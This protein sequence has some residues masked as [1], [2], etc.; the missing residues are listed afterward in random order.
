M[1]PLTEM[2]WILYLFLAGTLAWAGQEGLAD[3]AFDTVPFAEWQ[4]D[5]SAGEARIGWTLQVVPA[6]LTVHQRL[7]TVVLIDMEGSEFKKRSKP[8]QLVVFLEFRDRDGRAYRTHRAVTIE[9]ERKTPY[10][11]GIQ[12][13]QY[14]FVKDGDFEIAAAIYDSESKEH[15]L[16]RAKLRVPKLARDPLPDAWMD[17]PNLEFAD[18]PNPPDRWYLPHVKGRLHLPVPTQRPI[19]IEVLVNESPTEIATRRRER[20]SSRNMGN[21]IPALKV[22]TQLNLS[23]GSMNVTMLDLERRKVS[24]AQEDVGRLNWPRLRSALADNDPSRIDVHELENHEQNAQFFVAE[25]KKRLDA[26][27]SNGDVPLG[28]SAD[29]ARVLIVLSAPM[30]FPKGQDLRPIDAIPGSHVFYI[31][32]GPPLG[33]P[34]PGVQ[35]GETQGHRGPQPRGL[36]SSGAT[37]GP[38]PGGAAIAQDSLEATLKPLAPRR[39][40]VTNPAQFRNALA[41]IMSEISRIK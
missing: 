32:Y 36:D 7:A 31:R 9:E 39:F 30:A 24:F 5:G 20:I 37:P 33:P 35:M 14:A 12:F 11:S 1:I 2:R 18:A 41:A 28:L 13:E 10:F 4:K 16:K 34:L 15:S 29:P 38:A 23:D 3:R 40:D 25:V 22:I 8:G 21:L 27:E 17:L 6:R 26:T 19:H